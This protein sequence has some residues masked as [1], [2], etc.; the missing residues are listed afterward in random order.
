M[1]GAKPSL[2]LLAFLYH[3]KPF[4]SLCFHAFVCA[5][6]I[7]MGVLLSASL[8]CTNVLFG[9]MLDRFSM[10]CYDTRE[11]DYMIYMGHERWDAL[12]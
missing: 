6:I 10:P 3:F 7:G 12:R 8:V 4:L 1:V 5:C 9:Y 2:A 11:I